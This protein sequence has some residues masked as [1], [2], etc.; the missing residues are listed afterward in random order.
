MTS[1]MERRAFLA[2]AA[3]LL[4]APLAAEAQ[5][6]RGVPRVG[7]V[8]PGA[9]QD[10]TGVESFMRGLHAL[11]WVEGKTVLIETRYADGRADRIP[12]LSMELASLKVN[13]IV[14]VGTTAIQG[15]RDATTD[16]PIVMAGGGDPV[17]TGLVTTLAQP[18]GRIT[19]V[20]LAGK[21]VLGKAVEL[22]KTAVSRT[23]RIGVLMNA[24][25]PANGFLFK[26]MVEV[27]NVIGVQL[28]RIDVQ[29]G[30]DMD[31]AVARA[32][33]GALLVL[34]D[35]LFF[36]H[37]V[38]IA[39]LAIRLRLPSVF[40]G[41]PYAEA[42]GLLAYGFL[43]DEVWAR[44]AGLV[45]RILKGAKPGDLPVEQPTKF[46]LVINLKTAKALGL[47]IPP[48]LLLRADQVIE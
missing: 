37:R 12:G 38:R 11:G 35:P 40:I 20:S 41:R 17:G 47:T 22:L 28:H 42:G 45:N 34:A 48:S 16:I 13:V 15:V 26:E 3:A 14:T 27:G 21:E 19:G 18:G 6:A 9:R 32:Q 2:G 25:N 7:V 43:V 5:E 29:G 39:D 44:A 8:M 46:E 24:A 23:T 31:A 36:G 30:A 33:G 1:V 4:A 10:P